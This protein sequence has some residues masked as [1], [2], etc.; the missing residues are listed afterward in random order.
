MNTQQLERLRQSWGAL[1]T[2][3]QL[4]TGG[5]FVAAVVAILAIANF[6]SRTEYAL[7]YSGLE[8]AAAGEVVAALEQRGIAHEVRPGG[9]FVDA[10]QRDRLRFSLAAEGLPASAGGGYE[11]LDSLTGFGT[12]SQMF[13]A[14]YKR[15]KEGELARTI[16]ASSAIKSARV[17]ISSPERRGMRSISPGSASVFITPTRAT[18]SRPQVE[19][20]QFLVASAVGGLNPKMVSVV[21]SVSGRL[22]SD[23]EPTPGVEGELEISSTL[24]ARIERL[25][26]ARVGPG[27]AIV[28][29]NVSS[30]LDREKVIERRFDPESRVAI[31]T[32]TTENSA[33]S[34]QS[35]TGPVSVAS[36]LPDGDATG[37][38]EDSLSETE[39]RERVNY[40]VSETTREIERGP[41][42]IK[43]ITVAVLVNG[44]STVDDSGEVQTQPRPDTELL[45]LED[46]VKSAV[47]FDAERGDVVTLR[48]MGMP[49]IEP[50]GTFASGGFLSNLALDLNGLLRLLVFGLV[51]I[52]L[53][54]FF[55]R[56]LM[57]AA[58]AKSGTP[59]LADQSLP[60]LAPPQASS[61]PATS[62]TSATGINTQAPPALDGEIAGPGVPLPDTAEPARLPNK[63]D[64]VMRLREQMKLRKADS[65][66]VLQNWVEDTGEVR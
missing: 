33:T 23:G 49:S 35:S 60:P 36:N 10:T 14:T 15:A 20:L 64:A 18:L 17:H 31:S 52:V 7:L 56:P 54:L 6:A 24:R 5:V 32:E 28:E 44:I 29:V 26:E 50:Q 11:L 13:D 3:Q 25:L 55:V 27:N 58:F 30:E 22:L 21:D 41:G 40:E 4:M 2:K 34:N 42:T 46:L 66:A 39:T 8:A 53:S 45:A 63:A 19:A 1:G 9:I 43:R 65:V 59:V 37:G 62:E 12:T 48:S 38:G 16:A 57:M 47:G 51:A 61:M